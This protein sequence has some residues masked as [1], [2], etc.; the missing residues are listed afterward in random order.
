M[1]KEEYKAKPLL[2]ESLS[3]FRYFYNTVLAIERPVLI[4]EYGY[5]DECLSTDKFAVEVRVSIGKCSIQRK[6]CYWNVSVD[7]KACYR[8]DTV[9]RKF[10]IEKPVLVEILVIDMTVS[11]GN[12]R[13]R[14]QPR[15]INF[16]MGGKYN[17]TTFIS[18]AYKSLQTRVQYW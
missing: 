9:V 1:F 16:L 18:K 10:P 5:R 8:E 13:K 4:K 12:L 17:K 11:I 7:W 2:K 15:H 6:V 14:D 3:T